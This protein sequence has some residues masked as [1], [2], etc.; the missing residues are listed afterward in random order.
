MIDFAK[1]LVAGR[2]ER[3]LKCSNVITMP[4]STGDRKREALIIDIAVEKICSWKVIKISRF[5]SCV[6]IEKVKQPELTY[7]SRYESRHV[8]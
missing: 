1:Y 8:I 5:Y 6:L 7:E 4:F 2:I 3:A